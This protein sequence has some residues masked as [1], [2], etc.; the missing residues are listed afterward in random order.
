MGRVS[1]YIPGR[2]VPK[3]RPRFGKGGRAYTDPK[4]RAAEVEVYAH[5]LAAG[6]VHLEGQLRAT[7]TIDRDGAT[8]E[9][10]EIDEPKS[11]LRGDLD[12]YAKL[13]LDALNGAAYDDDRQ[14]Q[15]LIIFKK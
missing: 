8:V 7:V 15:H 4:T 9:V 3:G 11:P 12:N 2:P 14:I 13:I 10:E 5:W 6:A 1:F